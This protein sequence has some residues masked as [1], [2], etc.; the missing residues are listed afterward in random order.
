M[1]SRQRRWLTA[2]N[3]VLSGVLALLGFASCIGGEAPDEYGTPYAK[4][5]IK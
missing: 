2:C 5:E 3:Q 1:K 4:Y